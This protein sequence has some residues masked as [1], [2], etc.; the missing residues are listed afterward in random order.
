M[1]ARDTRS[2][3][4]RAVILAGGT[5]VSTHAFQVPTPGF[6]VGCGITASVDNSAAGATVSTIAVL[7]KR[8]LTA[9]EFGSGDDIHF[10]V[11]SAVQSDAAPTAKVANS[12]YGYAPLRI[13]LQSQ[14]IIYLQ[15]SV[16]ATTGSAYG[17]IQFLPD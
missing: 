6:V 11:F 14:Q 1:P 5:G 16:S 15:I 2:F 7:A 8:A 9:T 17:F 3:I 13:R 4:T 10:M 12:V